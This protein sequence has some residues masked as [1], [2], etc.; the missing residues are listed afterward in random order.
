M[1]FLGFTVVLIGAV[2]AS[3]QLLRLVDWLGR[4]VS[5]RAGHASAR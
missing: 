5:R 1:T 3:S 4:P 2:T